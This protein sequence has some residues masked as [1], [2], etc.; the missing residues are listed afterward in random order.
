MTGG[1]NLDENPVSDPQG[2]RQDFHERFMAGEL[3]PAGW[4]TPTDIDPKPVPE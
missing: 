4:I 3:E 1:P 2:L